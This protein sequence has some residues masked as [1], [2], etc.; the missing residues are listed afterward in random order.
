MPDV[1][2]SEAVIGSDFIIGEK[3]GGGKAGELSLSGSPWSYP[4]W[5]L[6]SGLPLD[7]LPYK[8]VTFGR[9]LNT[10]GPW[11]GETLVS[12]PRVQQFN[13]KDA[14]RTGRTLL[15]VDLEGVLVWSGI[16]WTRRYRKTQMGK[17]PV[18]ASEINSWFKQRLQAFNYESTWATEAESIK[19]NGSG[20]GIVEKIVNDAL[21][22]NNFG[23]GLAITV[24]THEVGEA[25]KIVT[26]YPA[27]S[28]QSLES[29]IS[30]LA[31]MGYG[32]GLDYSIDVQYR[33]GTREPELILNLWFPRMGRTYAESGIVLLDKDC[34][35]WEYPE[36]STSQANEVV[37]TGSG[38]TGSVPVSAASETPRQ[39][40]E[41]D[42]YPL[43]QKVSSHTQIIS[44][45]TLADVAAGDLGAYCYPV[46]TPWIEL[47]LPGPLGFGEFSLGDDL[48]WR[49][50]PVAGGGENT[51]PR[52]PEGMSFE[53][54]MTGWNCTPSD[55]GVSKLL[56][57]L[58][59]PPLAVIPPPQPPL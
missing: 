16:L 7:P 45:A 32:V 57:D 21:S 56:L 28:L 18:G 24:M 35:D 33:P 54:R 36:D 11:A 49:V 27:T 58:A 31:Q 37:E 44:D 53:W 47:P 29:I 2:G 43:L 12:D 42:G 13:W 14:S 9:Q 55:V 50:D 52:F 4:A 48:L 1:I 8:N 38:T 23:G 40:V 20:V 15:C 6:M 39:R 41:L 51:N 25:P 5:D 26:Q 59:I 10:P 30:T 34:L 22:V 19:N 17:L 46:V 3:A